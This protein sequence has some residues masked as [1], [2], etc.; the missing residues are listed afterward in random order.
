MSDEAAVETETLVGD[1]LIATFEPEVRE[2]VKALLP[3]PSWNGTVGFNSEN[4]AESQPGVL[5]THT[6]H[7]ASNEISLLDD[8]T[9]PSKDDVTRIMAE[10][11][12]GTATAVGDVLEPLRQSDL[13]GRLFSL[14]E[15]EN[16]GAALVVI[17]IV[18]PD[19]PTLTAYALT[20]VNFPTV[21]P[22]ATGTSSQQMGFRLEPPMKN[23]VTAIANTSRLGRQMYKHTSDPFPKYLRDGSTWLMAPAELPAPETELFGVPM[24]KSFYFIVE[25]RDEI[26]DDIGEQPANSLFF[27]NKEDM[28]QRRSD[29][30]TGLSA[31]EASTPP[32]K[33]CYVLSPG[34]VYL[35]RNHGLPVG[36]LISHKTGS[37][38]NLVKVLTE[39]MQVEQDKIDFLLHPWIDAFLQIAERHPLAVAHD[40]D[41]IIALQGPFP[42]LNREKVDAEAIALME[43]LGHNMFLDFLLSATLTKQV[44]KSL[45][46]YLQVVLASFKQ[47]FNMNT[48]LPSATWAFRFFPPA[49]KAWHDSLAFRAMNQFPFDILPGWFQT[50]FA[51]TPVP[52]VMTKDFITLDSAPDVENDETTAQEPTSQETERAGTPVQAGEQLAEDDITPIAVT[53]VQSIKRLRQPRGPDVTI[54]ERLNQEYRLGKQVGGDERDLALPPSQEASSS[55]QRPL[56]H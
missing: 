1:R 31:T 8:M 53:E 47:Q 32:D 51:P 50:S 46:Q 2:A 52:R 30:Y 48:N 27:Q 54:R 25:R 14:M 3:D 37:A 41:P 33:K 6:D 40:V 9:G 44:A 16:V 21:S 10:T 23:C 13:D 20:V 36:L 35:P 45:S 56:D 38:K 17:Q 15:S 39:H 19:E 18:A 55:D 7:E 43:R 4:G 22:M 26:Y 5:R 11:T 24:A 29:V 34:A 42:V 49:T 28:M 12:L